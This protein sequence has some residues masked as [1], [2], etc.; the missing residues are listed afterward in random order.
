MVVTLSAEEV[1]GEESSLPE[2][3]DPAR[4]AAATTKNDPSNTIRER[5]G[6]TEEMEPD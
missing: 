3:Q 4:S 6:A 1:E 5:L 2:L